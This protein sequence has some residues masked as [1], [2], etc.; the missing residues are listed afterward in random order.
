MAGAGEEGRE[1]RDAL[2]ELFQLYE[3]EP[4]GSRPPCLGEPR[5]PQERVQLRTVEH[6]ADV[7]PMVQILDAPVP[8]G[9]EQAGDQLVEVLRKID[10]RSSHQVIEVPK[11]FPVSAPLRRVESRPPQLAEQLVEVPTQPWYVAFVL[12]SK[13]YSRRELRRII[14]GAAGVLVQD[15]IQQRFW[16]RSMKILFLMVVAGVV[17]VEV[18]KVFSQNRIQQWLWSRSLI[19]PLAE[20]FQ[21]FSWARVLL[22][23]RV[24]CVT[25]QMRILQGFFA[26]FPVLKKVRSWARTRGRNCLPSRAHPRGEL[27]RTGMLLGDPRR[28]RGLGCPV[29]GHSC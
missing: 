21:V 22:P 1:E 23:H 2:P 20:V 13:V 11:V 24:V 29:L 28:L 6:I 27:M 15:R 17:L 5:G 4:G 19:F 8:R 12:A 7:V 10:T 9:G 25:M 18:F 3:E 26:L 14:A 16:S